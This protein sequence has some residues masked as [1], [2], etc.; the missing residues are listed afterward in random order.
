MPRLSERNSENALFTAV[1]DEIAHEAAAIR[2]FRV[3][4]AGIP[5]SHG[6]NLP[7]S[8]HSPGQTREYGAG[9]IMQ[10][11]YLDEHCQE[12]LT[13]PLQCSLRTWL[14]ILASANPFPAISRGV[15]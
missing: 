8:I 1:K 9:P 13:F 4:S 10:I 11:H 6:N 14:E 7:F 2:I 3:R 15:P 12:P 5:D